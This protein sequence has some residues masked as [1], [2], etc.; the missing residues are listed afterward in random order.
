MDD[1]YIENIDEFVY[2]QNKIVTYKWLSLTLGVHVNQAKQMLYHYLEKKRKECSASQLHATYLVSGKFQQN[3]N[4]CHKVTVVREDQ[5]EDIKSKLIVT[6]SIHVYSIQKAALKDSSPLFSTDYDIIKEN[7]DNCSKYSAIRC[8]IAAPRTSEEISRLQSLAHV[9]TPVSDGKAVTSKPS[10]N[11]DMSS[12]KPVS[13]QAKGIMGMFAS[14]TTSKSKETSKEVKTE[15]KA[16]SATTAVADKPVNKTKVPNNFFGKAATSKS[17]SSAQDEGKLIKEETNSQASLSKEVEKQSSSSVVKPAPDI[18]E[19]IPKTSEVP[20]KKPKENKTKTKRLEHSDSENEKSESQKKK[21][22][23]IKKP[24][25]ESS[26][27]EVIPDSPPSSSAKTSLVSPH[28]EV[29]KEPANSTENTSNVRRRKKRKVLKSRTSM[30]EEG[31]IVTE[32]VYESESYSE[33]EDDFSK[34][35]RT[36]PTKSTASVKTVTGKKDD[37][38]KGHKKSPASSNKGSK[39]ASIMGFFQKK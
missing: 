6:A 32:K 28:K 1:L 4:T 35:S 5:L 18:K 23:R 12:T 8:A 3:G 26:D 25:P 15:S 22:R 19:E 21:R 24:Q 11:G 9:A 29:K 14:K 30:D 2:D 13:Q 17:K 16:D 34:S 38:K 33:S 39:Q 10:I 37:E 36:Q 7:L 27:E 20:P 31:C